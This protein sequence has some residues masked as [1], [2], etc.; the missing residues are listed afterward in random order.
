MEKRLLK[1]IGK[2]E[3]IEF[4]LKIEVIGKVL[5]YIQNLY[6]I[7]LL[8]VIFINIFIIDVLLNKILNKFRENPVKNKVS[9]IF[10]NKL[11]NNFI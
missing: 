4:E 9:S 7:F 8:L 5:I 1:I 10:Y 11:L 6:F 2:K 3:E